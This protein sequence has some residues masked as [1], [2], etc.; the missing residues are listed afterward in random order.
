MYVPKQEEV[1]EALEKSFDD[2]IAN[3]ASFQNLYL[4][5]AGKRGFY[6]KQDGWRDDLVCAPQ[7]FYVYAFRQLCS[8]MCVCVRSRSRFL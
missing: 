8:I 6:F 5:L 7:N 3:G 1:K 2:I 4:Q